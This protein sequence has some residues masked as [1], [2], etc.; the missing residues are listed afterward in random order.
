V[1]PTM[2]ARRGDGSAQSASMTGRDMVTIVS[3]D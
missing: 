3:V 1:P 2:R